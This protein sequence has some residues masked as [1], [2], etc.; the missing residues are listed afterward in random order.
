MVLLLV[1]FIDVNE[2]ITFLG[3]IDYN[4][5]AAIVLHEK[6]Q[7]EKRTKKIFLSL[8]IFSGFSLYSKSDLATFFFFF[9]ALVSFTDYFPLL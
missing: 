2:S 4:S 8:K 5:C 7:N 3:Q 1:L 6:M 9:L